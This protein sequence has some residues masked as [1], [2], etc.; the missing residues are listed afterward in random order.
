MLEIKI[1]DTPPPGVDKDTEVDQK[2]VAF[3]KNC[4]GKLVTNDYNLN[5][6][7]QLREVDVININDLA[8]AMKAIVLPGEPMEVKIVKAGEE[9]EQGIAYLDDGTMI[10]VENGRRRIGEQSLITV[11]S[12]LQT[13]AG[14]MIFG[15][16]ERPVNSSRKNGSNNQRNKRHNNHSENK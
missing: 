2:L 1:D 5:K 8:N 13:S 3:T 14:R 10:V 7:A 11:T 15:K 6:V 9:A 16:Y 12:A 4:D